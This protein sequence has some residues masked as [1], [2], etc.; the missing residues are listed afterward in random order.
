MFLKSRG[1]F[2]LLGGHG[3]WAG[4]VPAIFLY[5][6]FCEAFHGGKGSLPFLFH[7]NLAK[8]EP[9]LLV[10]SLLRGPRTCLLVGVLFLR[11]WGA[12]G[13][14][15]WFLQKCPLPWDPCSLFSR[16][17]EAT[18]RVM[19]GRNTSVC[20]IAHLPACVNGL[21]SLGLEN[22]RGSKTDTG[23]HQRVSSPSTSEREKVSLG[24]LVFM[25]K[26]GF[27]GVGC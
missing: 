2:S 9:G 21:C 22:R 18:E 16:A 7:G 17:L 5:Q 26:G 12:P 24:L 15:E 25:V 19:G 13:T 11:D 27:L 8:G 3:Y 14:A 23:R 6:V 1:N 10:G 20:C 4:V